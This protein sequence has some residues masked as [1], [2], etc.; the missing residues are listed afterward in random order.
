MSL[1]VRKSVDTL[2]K[3]AENDGGKG[4]KR[5]LG[6]PGLVALGI[7]VIIGA[8][9]FSVTGVVAGLHTGPAI[10]LSF[11]IAAVACAFAGLCYAEFASMIP[12][13][14]SAYSYSYLTM[15][16]LVAWIIGWDLVL[17]YAVAA[18]TVSIS[19]SR[20]FCE[21]MAGFG[22]HLPHEFTACPTEGGIVN[23]PA[24]IIVVLLSLI[25]MRGTKG[26]ARFNDL[27][28]VLK[29]AVVLAFI[30][31]GLKYIHTENL[32]PFVPEN[33]GQFGAFGWSG[34]LRGAAIVFFA[35]IGFDAVST[36]A[37]ETKNPRRNM[38][39]GILGSLFICTII[40]ILFAF[41][42]V[43]VVDYHVYAGDTGSIAPAAIAVQHMGEVGGKWRRHPGLS[44]PEYGHHR[45]YTARLFQCH[46][47]HADGAE[48]RVLLH[49]Q[50]RP[51][52]TAFLSSSSAFPHAGPQQP[53]L[54]ARGERL[55]RRGARPDCR[56]DDQ[57]RHP[58]CLLISLRRCYCG[59]SH[60][61]QCASRLQDAACALR[62]CTWRDVLCRN[63]AF[64]PCRD[65][66][67][68]GHLDAHRP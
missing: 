6:A 26:S 10:T 53:P 19:W 49:E 14:G 67:T 38:P 40:Y 35:Y 51:A 7:G 25:L 39:I 61:A 4:M 30:V 22:W 45:G 52:A 27:I 18:M 15:G 47:R 55:C 21:L 60:N 44:G 17:E 3:E 1:F 65:V 68:T 57:H 12:I 5:V 41:V 24:M 16:E 64:P 33:T 37:Q 50:R 29:I 66:D 11:L 56:R 31:L 59:S 43:G 42:M 46:T 20:Y 9:L 13:S 48:S 32:T 34:V 2:L 63:D 58:V 36:A 28:V 23:L 8:G 54:H 62:A